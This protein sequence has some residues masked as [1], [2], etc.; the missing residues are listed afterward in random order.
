M[1]ATPTRVWALLGLL[2]LFQGGAFGRRSF[3][4]SRDECQL[5]RIK[6]FE[7]SLRVEA[8]GGVTELWDPLNEQ[9]RCGGAHA[10]RHVIYPNATLLPSYTGSP[11]I[12]Y[13][14]QGTPLF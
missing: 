10:F 9:F 4:G 1:A 11:L 13:T 8:E 3:T 6:A 12:A 2:L 5:R 7:P 14:L